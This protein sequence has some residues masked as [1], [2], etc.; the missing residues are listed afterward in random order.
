MYSAINAAFGKLERQ[1]KRLDSMLNDHWAN[2]EE[3][4]TSLIEETE[5][6]EDR[7]ENSLT[8]ER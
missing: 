7:A 5:E 3:F 1:L 8:A 2:K 4:V 6:N